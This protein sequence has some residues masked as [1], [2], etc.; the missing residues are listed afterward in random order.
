MQLSTLIRTRLEHMRNER[1][2]PEQIQTQQLRK[3]RRLAKHAARHSPYYRNII[4]TRESTLTAACHTTFRFLPRRTLFA[5]SI[6]S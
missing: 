1:R 6:T 4:E 5:S 3:F 2:T